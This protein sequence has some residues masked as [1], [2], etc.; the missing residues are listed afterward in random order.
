VY[1]NSKNELEGRILESRDE[2]L[3]FGEIQY[4]EVGGRHVA[5]WVENPR[6]SAVSIKRAWFQARRG[7]NVGG[8]YLNPG[9]VRRI[10]ELKKSG[11][12]PGE[13]STKLDVGKGAVWGVYYGRTWQHVA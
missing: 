10:R 11:M 12:N 8:A 7:E 6:M 5:T 3:A 13:I 2:N 9:L 4:S 1:A